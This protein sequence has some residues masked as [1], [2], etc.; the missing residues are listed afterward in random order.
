MPWSCPWARERP[1]ISVSRPLHLLLQTTNTKYSLT[2]HVPADRIKRRPDQVPR[3]ACVSM[4]ARAHV[5]GGAALGGTTEEQRVTWSRNKIKGARIVNGIVKITTRLVSVRGN[6]Q[7]IV[8]PPQKASPGAGEIML[9]ELQ[10]R[11]FVVEVK[12]A[13]GRAMKLLSPLA[14]GWLADLRRPS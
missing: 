4:T 9:H 2:G 14:R 11:H 12:L 5:P 6:N 1:P 3:R 8:T 10:L 13:I 7:H